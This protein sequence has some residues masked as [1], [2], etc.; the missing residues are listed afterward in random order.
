MKES[1]EPYK[2]LY[3]NLSPCKWGHLSCSTDFGIRPVGLVGHWLE[4]AKLE[5]LGIDR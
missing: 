2:V 4:R 5:R 3:P 1:D